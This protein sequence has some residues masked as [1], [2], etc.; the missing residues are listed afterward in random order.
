[1]KKRNVNLLMVVQWLLFMPLLLP[2]GMIAGAIDGV[3]KTLD[4]ANADIFD[5]EMT[6]H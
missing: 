4:R 2:M 3:K 1:M 6:L 5:E